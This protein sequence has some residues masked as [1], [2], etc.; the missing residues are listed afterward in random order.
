MTIRYATSLSGELV[1]DVEA[2]KAENNSRS[3]EVASLKRELLERED[4][5]RK[6]ELQLLQELEMQQEKNSILLNLLD[7]FK[8]RADNAE[9]F[10]DSV[11]V[12]ILY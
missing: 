1:L 11:S 12:W 7:V 6:T 8:E 10:I 3:M 9:K 5:G 4:F 2:L